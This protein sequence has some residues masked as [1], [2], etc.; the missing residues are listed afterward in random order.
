MLVIPFS[1]RNTLDPNGVTPARA[2]EAAVTPARADEA[3][4]ASPDYWL[5]LELSGLISGTSQ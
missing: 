2:D 4:V 3:A 1:C 5:F